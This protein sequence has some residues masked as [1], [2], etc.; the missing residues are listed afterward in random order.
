[1]AFDRGG[2]AALAPKPSGGRIIRGNKMLAQE[3]ALLARFS[4]REHEIN[5]PPFRIELGRRFRFRQGNPKP[6]R[7]SRYGPCH[8]DRLFD[9]TSEFPKLTRA[10]GEPRRR[11]C[12]LPP[13]RR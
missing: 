6:S 11:F 9:P 12:R 2:L 1:M 13:I 5:L 10:D 8:R 7:G 4:L 3:E